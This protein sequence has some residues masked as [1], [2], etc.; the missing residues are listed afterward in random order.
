MSKH[1]ARILTPKLN[2]LHDLY[3][4]KFKKDKKV[5]IFLKK[6]IYSKIKLISTLKLDSFT[7]RQSYND[8]KV[9][10]RQTFFERKKCMINR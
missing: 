8:V 1:Y 10:D 2:N 6:I 3:R 9:N 5:N 7:G 4:T